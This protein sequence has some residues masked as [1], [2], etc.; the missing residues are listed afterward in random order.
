[1]ARAPT[2][3][4]G[5]AEWFGRPLSTLDSVERARCA[6]AALGEIDRPPCP[7]LSSAERSVSCSKEGGVCSIRAYT[8]SAD[9]TAVP[10][11]TEA[12]SICITCPNRFKEAGLIYRWIG[13]V[14]LRDSNPLVLSEIGF[15]DPVRQGGDATT[16]REVGQIDNILVRRN[17]D[18]LDWC[19]VEVQGVYFSGGKMRPEF[20]SLRNATGSAMPF[21]TGQ[22]RPDFRSSAPKRLMPQLQIKVP[23]LVRW[24][25]RTAVVIDAAFFASLGPMNFVEDI[26]NAEIAWF[27]VYVSEENGRSR[28]MRHMVRFTTLSSAVEGLTAG[29][30]VTQTE[31][32]R[33]IRDRLERMN[34]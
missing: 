15:L 18:P 5:I 11:T 33:R 28:I 26:S 13:E 24:G 31:F 23:T 14:L 8:R 29:R 32:E 1:M 4:Y 25:R 3:R 22:R 34:S 7:F 17:S 6:S 10:A 16:R 20:V 12:T 9:G 27:V 21:P 2:P 30:P 19:A